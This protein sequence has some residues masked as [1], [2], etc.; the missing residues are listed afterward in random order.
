MSKR[1]RAERQRSP[2]PRPSVLL[3]SLSALLLA[4]PRARGKSPRSAGGRGEGLQPFLSP[5]SISRRRS[6]SRSPAVPGAVRAE[7]PRSPPPNF[8]PRSAPRAPG[9]GWGKAEQ[10]TGLGSVLP[11]P[12]P[13]QELPYWW[14]L[15]SSRVSTA[16]SGA[17]AAGRPAWVAAPSSSCRSAAA[18]SAD[19]LWQREGERSSRKCTEQR[20]AVRGSLSVA[21]NFCSL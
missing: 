13:G 7:L 21:P 15:A 9:R 5:S 3:L 17:A 1:L 10:R 14:D 6:P 11:S 20:L 2:A 18:D 8:A 16:G 19:F 12:A 4:S